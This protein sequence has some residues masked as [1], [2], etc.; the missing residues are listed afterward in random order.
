MEKILFPVLLLNEDDILKTLKDIFFGIHRQP[1]QTN[2]NKC[3]T[4]RDI[5]MNVSTRN[6]MS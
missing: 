6:N 5:L 3:Y 1:Q 2:T 4:Y